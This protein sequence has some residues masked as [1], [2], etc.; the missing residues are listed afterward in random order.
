M[1]KQ[2]AA[3]GFGNGSRAALPY[4][5][6]MQRF[7][8]LEVWRRSHQFALATYRLT[9]TL[10]RSEQFGIVAQLRRAA[11]S[12][13]ANI[14]EGAKRLSSKDYERFLNIAEGSLAECQCLLL[15]SRDLGFAP[16]ES[17]A[18]LLGQAAAIALKLHRLRDRVHRAHS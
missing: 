15:L 7:T 10:P 13:S 8:E 14:A 2:Y 11:V 4:A 3:Q 9:A 5:F 6:A 17:A 16:P 1:E 12:V 18:A